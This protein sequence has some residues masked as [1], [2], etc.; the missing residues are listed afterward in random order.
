MNED[1]QYLLEVNGLSVIYGSEDNKLKAVDG[2]SLQM[3]EGETIGV[4][5]ESGSGKSTLA[6]AIMGLIKGGEIKGEIVYDGHDL[7]GLSEKELK[8][9]RWQKVALVFQNSL[10]VLN[11]VLTIGEQIREPLQTHY[12]LSKK[13][14]EGRVIE[15]LNLVG[16]NPE[17]RNH[18]PHN[19]SGGMRQRVL[20]AM[21]LSCD[22][23][24][25]IIDEPTT[26]L[27]PASKEEILQLLNKL[28]KR[29]G[30]AMLMIS[31]DLGTIKELTSQ[32]M[33]MYCGQVVEV[34]L[35]EKVFKDPLHPYT[36]GLLNSSPNLFKYKDLW[37]IEGE[38]SQG[39]GCAFSPRCCQSGEN[40]NDSR[41]SL[42]YVA[43]ERMVACHKGGI[44]KFLE[45]RDIK[46]TYRM[47]GKE[48][49][50]VKGVNLEI[51]SGEV[52]ALVGKSGS[53]KSTV[54][55]TLVGVKD[56]DEG[57]I[58]YRGKKVEDNWA[59]K[60]IGGMQ[61]VFQD[62]SSSISSRLRVLD[63]IKEPLDII[64]WGNQEAR[65]EKVV[66]CLQKVQLPASK[67]FLDRYCHA[68]S[69]G[70]R[71]RIAIA[72]ALVTEP[73]LLIADEITS[74]LDPSTQANLLRKLKALQNRAGFA[75]LYITHDLHLVRKI[76][77]KVCVM[78]GGEIVERGVSFEILEN[79]KHGYTKKL[80]SN[81]FRSLI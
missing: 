10:E 42:E 61:I 44:E 66:E 17:W 1:N 9:F 33:T 67:E 58:Y 22:P 75:M 62:P 7:V 21:A 80:L 63:A 29:L 3:K 47:K 54:A 35:T 23:E 39:K 71:Q 60:M 12:D 68:L 28:Q 73:K 20:L 6:L 34:G 72:R 24:L 41:P 57:E 53:G 48:V 8:E 27:D 16:L 43:L 70:Q 76:A 14:L 4:I 15:L 13:E 5:G 65:K 64:K 74:S 51:K 38:V 56:F 79:P 77:D 81:A 78:H 25:L 19:L 31:H 30:F 2:L 37:G 55:H 18:Y 50:A 11:P 46:K 36:R 49:K 32:V 26:A 59:T 52:V 40:C 45:A 69:G